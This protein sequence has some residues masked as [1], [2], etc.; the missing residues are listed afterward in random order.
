M[1]NC[2]KCNQPKIS[3]ESFNKLGGNAVFGLYEI[4]FN[5]FIIV[6]IS[7]T[8]IHFFNNHLFKKD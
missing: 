8:I 2:F 7:I 3:F 5:E 4:S 1:H 6:I